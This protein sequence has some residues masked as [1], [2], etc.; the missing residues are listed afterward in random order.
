MAIVLTGSLYEADAQTNTFPASGNVGIGTTSPTESL[1]V[2]GNALF[3][4]MSN[5]VGGGA[6]VNF[7]S[8]DG[9]YHLGPRIRSYLDF[10]SGTA[11]V[12]RLILSSYNN[13]YKDELTLKDGYVGV[14]TLV[15]ATRLSVN[16]GSS[17]PTSRNLANSITVG[18]GN[19]NGTNKYL[20]QLGFMSY[21]VD[22]SAPKM[23]AFIGAEATETYD[24]ATKTGSVLRFFTGSNNGNNPEERMVIN[25]YGNVGIGTASPSD[26]L[27][28][29]GRIRAQEIKVETANWPDY[30][31]AKGYALPSLSETEHHIK[32]KGHL[33]GIPSATE[34]KENGV[35]LGEMN[36]KLLEKIEE[37]T[38]HLIEME[39]RVKELESH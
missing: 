7:S 31:F 34:V 21:D 29:N 33:P 3:R 23:V 18:V 20:G 15:P 5:T 14:N 38:L 39:K 12:S 10:A 36:K 19:A 32:E 24:S 9:N 22:F 11:S 8:F 4:N 1:D 2:A 17:A 16:S 30:V 25:N 28:V 27:S 35:E 13:G 26:K 6:T 37:L